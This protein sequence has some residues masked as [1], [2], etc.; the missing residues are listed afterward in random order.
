M[1][2]YFSLVRRLIVLTGAVALFACTAGQAPARQPQAPAADDVQ[3]YAD[4]L[5][6]G[7]QNW[8]WD[9]TVDFG[10]TAQVHS[11]T[12]AAAVDLDAAFAGFS[13]R[14]TPAISASDYESIT[15]WVYGGVGGSALSLAT[16]PTDGGPGSP[17]VAVAAPAGTWTEFNVPLSSLGSPAS[18]ARINLM[19][20]TGTNLPVWYL[21]D[22]RL[23]ARDVPPL[24]TVDLTLDL[25]GTPNA[26]TPDHILGTNFAV[27]SRPAITNPTF[28]ARTRALGR[29]LLRLPGGAFS[30]EYGGINCEL[31]AGAAL[32]G[33]YPCSGDWLAT[34]SDLLDFLQSTERAGLYTININTT[35]KEAAATVAFF[36]ASVGDPTV[37]GIDHK[38]VNW[39]TAGYW[40]QLRSDHGNPDPIG[41]KYWDFGNETYGGTQASGGAECAAFGWE[42]VWTCNGAEYI[43]GVGAGAARHQGYLEFRTAM[44]AIDPTILVGAIGLPDPAAF[45]N[46]SNELLA[47]G[48]ATIDYYGI[49]PYT[50]DEVPNTAT[51][52][53]RPQ[54]QWPQIVSALQ[55]AFATHAG[56]RSIPIWVTEYNLT[57][58]WSYDTAQQMTRAVNALFIADTIGQMITHKMAVGNQWELNGNTQTNGTDYGLLRL[59]EEELPEDTNFSARS[60]HYYAYVLWDRFGAQML[61][62]AN[63]AD[64]ATQLSV[65]GG[66]VD[67]DTLSLLAINKTAA[68]ISANIRLNQLGQPVAVTGGTVD[69]MQATALSDQSVTWN[70]VASPSDDLSNAPPLPFAATGTVPGHTFPAYSVTLLRLNTA[71][72]VLDRQVFV[73]LVRR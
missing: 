69:L 26:F 56:G 4:A 31:G 18:I 53:S 16:Q 15:F 1:S 61:P 70:T 65:Y 52:L 55:A 25:S 19:D 5:A 63:S 48:G 54:Q 41:I 59:D 57:S 30:Q 13:L 39:Q 40:A 24:G 28:V 8:S 58:V 17:T 51:I 66:R 32:P 12:A 2:R 60:P 46:W 21:D 38:G 62:V 37:I 43:N 50:F 34:L 72:V 9:A 49:H 22:L 45:S 35:A 10:A 47:A 27:W 71:A 11:G 33:A 36:N 64:A 67:A 73:P 20:A 14:T 44:K 6:G 68:P 23:V 3:I 29:G 42:L 7:W